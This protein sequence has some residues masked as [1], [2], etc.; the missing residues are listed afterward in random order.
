MAHIEG[1][2]LC[3]NLRY[4]YISEIPVSIVAQ[5]YSRGNPPRRKKEREKVREYRVGQS[6]VEYGN[7][8]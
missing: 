5:D 6:R 8:E 7:V 1:R 4:L 2:V 3:L